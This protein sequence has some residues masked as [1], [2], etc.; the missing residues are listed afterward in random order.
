MTKIYLLTVLCSLFFISCNC[1]NSSKCNKE[2]EECK[3]TKKVET[4]CNEKEKNE[5]AQ[6]IEYYIEGG[7]QANSK[8]TAKAFSETATMSWSEN[9]RLK[10]VPISVLYEIVDGGEPASASYQITDC[11][12]ESNIAIV[13]IE[14]QFGDA[15]YTDMFSLVKDGGEWKIISK[16]YH[17]K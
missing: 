15:K 14:S 11:N 9:G 1:N 16:I 7:R 4:M 13:R 12:I 10:S 8:I 17:V 6:T 5:I 3:T 2:S